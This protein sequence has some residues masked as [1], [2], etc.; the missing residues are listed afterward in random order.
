[1]LVHANY[2]NLFEHKLLLLNL[3]LFTFTY[4]TYIMKRKVLL[5]Y[6]MK[7]K[8]LFFILI[9]G[10][11][12]ISYSAYTY[13]SAP[14]DSYTNAPGESNCTSCH[15]GTALNGGGALNNITLT[16]STSLTSLLPNTTY[17]FSLSFNQASRIK[18][19]FQLC[20]LPSGANSS[21]ASIGTLIASGSGTQL[22]S[23]SSPNRTYLMH[24][25]SGTSA[26][27]AS[28]TWQFQYTTPNIANATPQFYVVINASNNNSSTSGD[29]IYAKTFAASV[30]PVK[31]GDVG[32]LINNGNTV[33]NWSTLTE[34]NNN[35]FEIEASLN[36][37]DW[38]VV[39]KVAGS[40]NTSVITKYTYTDL[41]NNKS[42]YYR[43]KQVDYNGAFDYSKVVGVK[44]QPQETIVP[45]FDAS[46][47]Q[48]LLPNI[49]LEDM[50][51]TGLNGA[52]FA[53][54]STI[55]NG[56]IELDVHYLPTG[57]YV[58]TAKHSGQFYYW[59][60]LVN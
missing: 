8:V 13:T 14:P 9:L 3:N 19:G 38:E 6:I 5:T 55:N 1:M 46:N 48:I 17:N 2:L 32:A 42:L 43:V 41:S 26:P 29:F 23:T 10:M 4:I 24:D 37:F 53:I 45:I 27:L 18:Y 25:A 30:L 52:D 11:F 54:N 33:I 50:K 20:V 60:I 16:T 22:S 56:L 7:R 12:F 40:G 35:Y 58:L 36:G 39:A 34:T 59:K 51:L 28:K 15:S 49:E 31:W 44:L 47:K 21:S 57:I